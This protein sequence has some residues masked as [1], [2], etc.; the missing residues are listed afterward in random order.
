MDARPDTLAAAARPAISRRIETIL[1]ATDLSPASD[2]AFEEA[3]RL[4]RDFGADLVIAH[5][6]DPTSVL[7]LGYVPAHA[8]LEWEDQFRESLEAKLAPLVRYAREEGIDA[9]SAVLTG[10]AE[11]AIIDAAER[12]HA[13]MILMGTHGRTG[14]SRF[15]LGSVASRVIAAAPC[16]VMTVRA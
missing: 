10:P 14:A 6:Y 8:Y 9:R 13:G 15:F 1:F 7:A 3:C 4:A 5:A 12:E 2:R 11:Q 16:P